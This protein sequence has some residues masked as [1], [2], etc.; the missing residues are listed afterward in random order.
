MVGGLKLSRS[1][2]ETQR[3]ASRD[4]LGVNSRQF[5]SIVNKQSDPT[6]PIS[7]CL[8]LS[9]RRVSLVGDQLK[10]LV[11]NESKRM[12]RDER[13]RYESRLATIMKIYRKVLKTSPLSYAQIDCLS[14]G[15]SRIHPYNQTQLSMLECRQALLDYIQTLNGYCDSI[16]IL[17]LIMK[18]S[19][20]TSVM[21]A[22]DCIIEKIFQQRSL[23]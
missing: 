15:N 1:T 5:N 18:S 2:R 13:E 16:N 10:F 9:E 7:N 17:R 21:H 20:M 19:S 22:F 14:S 8:E 23:V 11:R 6:R 12:S 4:S 3:V